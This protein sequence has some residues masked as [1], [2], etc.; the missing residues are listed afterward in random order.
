MVEDERIEELLNRHHQTI[1]DLPTPKDYIHNNFMLATS[2]MIERYIED[3]C[4]PVTEAEYE[5][6]IYAYICHLTDII[7]RMEWALNNASP[8]PHWLQH[9]DNPIKDYPN[10]V[11]HE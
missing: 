2:L 8:D 7:D 1:S 11:Q 4:D 6:G 9:V 10:E 5:L 3:W